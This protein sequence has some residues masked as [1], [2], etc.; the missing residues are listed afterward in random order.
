MIE[1]LY[2]NGSA[3]IKYDGLMSSRFKLT[4]GVR[5]GSLLSP[6]FYNIYIENL[7][8]EIQD[9]KV[10]TSI[11]GEFTGIV[12]YADD[13]ILMSATLSGLHKMVNKC[14]KYGYDH[15]IKFNA[16]KTKFIISG[17][18]PL[19][20][21]EVN[22]DGLA[23]TPTSTIKHLG[24]IWECNNAGI[25]DLQRS[26]TNHRIYEMWA[27]TDTLINSGIRFCHPNTITLYKSTIVP[28]LMYGLELCRSLNTSFHHIERQARSALKHL[29]NVSKFSRNILEEVF[30]LSTVRESIVINKLK[31]FTRLLKMEVTQKILMKQLHQGY[32]N[33]SFLADIVR[34]CETNELD[35][36]RLL[37]TR[38]SPKL[39]LPF[40]ASNERK[41]LIDTLNNLVDGWYL[42]ENR[43]AFK[44]LLEE[45][46]I[47]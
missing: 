39:K 47:R 43:S 21:V 16:V 38:K 42:H 34:I 4:Q 25:A 35:F 1:N 17:K 11:H 40:N 6:Y 37:I 7:L 10:G 20:K 24:F 5:Q 46:V 30:D 41:L 13:I 3:S 33:Q 14:V 22:L 8:N 45:R 23:I 29:F 9:M 15:K 12:C 19:K 27:I 28:K 26:Q 18:S 32:S 36:H 31:L 44:N 2:K